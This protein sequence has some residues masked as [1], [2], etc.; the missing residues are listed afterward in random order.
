MKASGRAWQDRF[1]H[2]LKEAG[3]SSCPWMKGMIPSS[4]LEAVSAVARNRTVASKESYL[5]A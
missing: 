5:I 3:G 4:E 1:D 2:D